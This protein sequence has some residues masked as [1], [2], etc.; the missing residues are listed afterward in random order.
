MRTSSCSVTSTVSDLALFSSS[1]STAQLP[2]SAPSAPIVGGRRQRDLLERDRRRAAGGDG[3]RLRRGHGRRS[4]HQRHASPLRPSP[5]SAR[6]CRRPRRS[7]ASTASAA[8][9]GEPRRRGRDEAARPSRPGGSES[10]A[11]TARGRAPAR[12]PPCPA[13]AGRCR[14]WRCRPA[15]ATSFR[16]TIRCGLSE[17]AGAVS[18]RLTCSNDATAAPPVS[19][20][21]VI[22]TVPP[23]GPVKASKLEVVVGR[24]GGGCAAE[25]DE[26]GGRKAGDQRRRPPVSRA[27]PAPLGVG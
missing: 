8:A 9:R 19:A 23:A 15:P 20:G 3:H 25:R 12:S 26:D 5:R 14:P 2:R 21:S 7:V 16:L 17:P 4:E 1:V 22:V 10:A 24:G 18:L 27:S 13:R 11:A 6:R